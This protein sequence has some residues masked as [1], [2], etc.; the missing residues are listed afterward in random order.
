MK[1]QT[2]TQSSA[3]AFLFDEVDALFTFGLIFA[4]TAVSQAEAL[5]ASS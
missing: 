3:W 5:L 2:P 4:F 1:S